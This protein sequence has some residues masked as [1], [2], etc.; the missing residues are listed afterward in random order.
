MCLAG[1]A[2]F[3]MLMRNDTKRKKRRKRR[4]MSEKALPLQGRILNLEI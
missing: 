1:F 4:K 3:F 2:S